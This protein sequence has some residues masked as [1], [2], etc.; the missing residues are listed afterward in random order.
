MNTYHQGWD[1]TGG[2]IEAWEIIEDGLLRVIWEESGVR[3]KVD[4]LC[5]IYATLLSV[6]L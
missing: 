1:S 2:Q 4:R 3:A 5:G 6:P